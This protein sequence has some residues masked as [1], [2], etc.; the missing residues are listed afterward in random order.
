[1][2]YFELVNCQNLFPELYIA[3]ICV[4]FPAILQTPIVTQWIKKDK[5]QHYSGLQSMVLKF[6]LSICIGKLFI[7]WMLY[8]VLKMKCYPFLLL[9]DKFLSSHWCICHP[10]H[11]CFSSLNSCNIQVM[12]MTL[13][14]TILLLTPS[15]LTW[16]Q[17]LY[18][19]NWF[20]SE[21]LTS[22][23]P[24]PNPNLL[25]SEYIPPVITMA[26]LWLHKA[27]LSLVSSFFS[28][29]IDLHPNLLPPFS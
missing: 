29:L 3:D 26:I 9:S 18:I 13:A 27:L 24:I 10:A 15:L 5:N 8:H 12:F 20:T 21:I 14:T 17:Q 11:R 4:P 28:H 22:N 6:C 25:V 16:S 19:Q 2:C 1:M 23:S 7:F